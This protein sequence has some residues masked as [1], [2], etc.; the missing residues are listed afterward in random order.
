MYK[1]I[2]MIVEIQGRP[3]CASILKPMLSLKV[4]TLAFQD[5]TQ[6]SMSPPPSWLSFPLTQSTVPGANTAWYT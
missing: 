1:T 3:S 4:Q 6:D 2:F 5:L